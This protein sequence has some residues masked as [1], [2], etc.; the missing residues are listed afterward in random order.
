MIPAKGLL[1]CF[2][3]RQFLMKIYRFSLVQIQT[4]QFSGLSSLLIFHSICAAAD[5]ASARSVASAGLPQFADHTHQGV[6]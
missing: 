2:V 4:S 5:K 6:G 1:L 3:G